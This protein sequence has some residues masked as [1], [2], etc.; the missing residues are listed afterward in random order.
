[1]TRPWRSIMT[2]QSRAAEQRLQAYLEN[3]RDCMV[4]MDLQG[5]VIYANNA[6]FDVM[7]ATA[8]QV[9]SGLS[10]LDLV[11]PESRSQAEALLERLSKGESIR[12]DD[13]VLLSPDGRRVIADGSAWPD[14]HE[15]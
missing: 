8:A 14:L 11:A 5:R 3:A 13:I 12:F 10:A 1:M 15:G 2:M 6:F 9:A 7:G 4:M